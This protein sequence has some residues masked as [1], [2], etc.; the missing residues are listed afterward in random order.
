M[1]TSLLLCGVLSLSPLLLVSQI[2][3]SGAGSTVRSRPYVPWKYVCLLVGLAPL[4][5]QR[6]IRVPRSQATYSAPRT[7]A[8]P[9]HEPCATGYVAFGAMYPPQLPEVPSQLGQP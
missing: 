3:P 8:M 5:A 7:T 4:M 1:T 2:P 9:L 6:Y